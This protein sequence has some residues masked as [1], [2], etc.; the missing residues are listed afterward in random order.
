MS[1]V[2][3]DFAMCSKPDSRDILSYAG[4]ASLS[5]KTIP[6]QSKPPLLLQTTTG[7]DRFG[8]KIYFGSSNFSQWPASHSWLSILVQHLV[9]AGKGIFSHR[10]NPNPCAPWMASLEICSNATVCFFSVVVV[11]LVVSKLITFLLF[12][13]DMKLGTPSRG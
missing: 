12:P 6:K 2:Q 11:C 3:P 4:L 1:L 5:W 13:V 7:E 10:P 9:P 8:V